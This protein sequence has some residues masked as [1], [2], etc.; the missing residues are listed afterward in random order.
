MT[1]GIFRKISDL[2]NEALKGKGFLG[3]ILP[4]LNK[5]IDV[6]SSIMQASPSPLV[7]TLGTGIQAANTT[8]GNLMST[9]PQ[10]GDVSD[11]IKFKV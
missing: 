2:F 10:Q 7:S 3:S 9:V 1:V 8:L 6:G 4:A 5:V 11:L